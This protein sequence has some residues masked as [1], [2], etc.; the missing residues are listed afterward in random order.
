MAGA[1]ASTGSMVT[2]NY[3]ATDSIQY[4]SNAAQKA[5]WLPAA[6]SGAKLGA[7]ALTEPGAGSNSVDMT[8]RAVNEGDGY[9]ISG[10][11]HFISNACAADL[12]VVYAKTDMMAGARGISASVVETAAGGVQVGSSEKTMG[13]KGGYV[14][15]IAFDCVVPVDNRL[16]D[17]G[18]G[19]RTALKVLDVG[20]LDIAACCVGIAEAAMNAAKAWVQSRNVGRHPIAQ[21]QGIQ[22]M[23]A[24]M[25]TDIAAARALGLSATMKRASGARFSLEA[26]M[27]KLFASEMV[28]R[29]TDQ[30]LQIHG[31]Y[32]Y[33]R[34]CLWSGMCGMRGSC[35]SMK[36]H[37]RS[38]ATSSHENLKLKPDWFALQ[39]RH[40]RLERL[41]CGPKATAPWSAA[42]RATSLGS[43]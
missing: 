23:L 18:S 27:T 30:V 6:A 20:R 3:L 37:L 7:F 11:K 29:V 19:F 43:I 25:A 1:C 42:G 32:G 39:P 35:G 15:E 38:S 17:E 36:D 26:S 16:G 13:L 24:D 14:F 5:R 28:G 34:G 10:T 8:T 9:R 31:G 33:S 41:A 40:R 2:A 21:F 12:I 22:W 4:G